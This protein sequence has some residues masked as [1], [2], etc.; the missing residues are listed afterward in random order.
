[1][2]EIEIFISKNSNLCLTLELL[3]PKLITGELSVDNL[4]IKT[5][6]MTS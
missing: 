2:K 3:L 4:D 6:G 5:E 1:M